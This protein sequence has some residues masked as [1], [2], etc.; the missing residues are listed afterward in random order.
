MNQSQDVLITGATGTIGRALVQELLAREGGRVFLLLRA[1]DG[2]S[3]EQRA[4]ELLHSAGLLRHFGGRA[5]ALA[6]DVTEPSFGLSASAQA[7]LRG[8]EVFHHCA[9]TTQLNGSREECERSNVRG[10]ERALELAGAL[11]ASGALERFAYYS[12]AYSP[13]SL[14][15]YHSPE[16]ELPATPAPANHYEWSKWVAEGRVREAMRAG[17]PTTIFRPSIV[18][19]HSRTGEVSEFKVI[20]PFIRLFAMGILRTV[21]AYPDSS[22][23]LVPIDFVA[24]AAL[25]I[26][27]RED[28][29]GKG[30][31]LVARTPTT[32]RMLMELKEKRYPDAPTVELVPPE[33]F[34]VDSLSSVERVAFEGLRPFLGYLHYDLTFDTRNAEA[35]LEGTDVAWPCTGL[36]FLDTLF[37]FALAKGY[38][39]YAGR[40][41]AASLA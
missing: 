1:K 13:G 15:N 12:T 34:T 6:G 26:C 29:L 22:L 11:R 31:H 10:T 28:S 32:I 24:Q 23:N 36:A 16:D 8:V 19:G 40:R 9:A 33:R 37:E 30:F 3:H 17:L 2:A 5:I 18:V 27:R 39:V 14:Q 35:L 20:Y 21:P 41:Q 7:E 4:A 25:A 38:F